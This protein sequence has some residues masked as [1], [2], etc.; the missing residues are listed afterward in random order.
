MFYNVKDT[1]SIDFNAGGKAQN[2][3]ALIP[4]TTAS[5]ATISTSLMLTEID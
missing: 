1:K 5:N 4:G 2:T 3:H